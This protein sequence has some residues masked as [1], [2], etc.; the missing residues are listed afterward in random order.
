MGKLHQLLAVERDVKRTA[1]KMS[2][3]TIAL[4]KNKAEHLKGVLR[5]YKKAFDDGP[6]FQPERKAM[7]TTVDDKLNYFIKRWKPYLDLVLQKEETNSSGNAIQELFVDNQSFGVYNATSLL[8]LEKHVGVIIKVIQNIPTLDPTHEW[9]EAE[10]GT[11]VS[12]YPEETQKTQKLTKPIVLYE[13]TKEHPAQVEMTSY[14]VIAG[15]W[16]TTRTSGMISPKRKAD[17]LE[18]AEKLLRAVQ[19]A[20][21]KAN[22]C[23]VINVDSSKFFDFVTEEKPTG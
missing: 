13:A 3:E 19:S 15:I 18:R 23:D 11:F 16:T 20:R 7:V 21:S 6:D 9:G 22:G 12:K 14:D 1:I 5:T 4:F 10:N 17:M 8:A 2:E